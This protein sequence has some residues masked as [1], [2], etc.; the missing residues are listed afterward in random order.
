M[1]ARRR[2]GRAGDCAQVYTVSVYQRLWLGSAQQRFTLRIDRRLFVLVVRFLVDASRLT[3]MGRNVRRSTCCRRGDF[4]STAL[5][6]I[7]V[8]RA[9]IVGRSEGENVERD[10]TARPCDRSH[11]K[12]QG[13]A[14]GYAGSNRQTR[15]SALAKGQGLDEEKK[16]EK[17]ARI[18]ALVLARTNLGR[19]VPSC[20]PQESVRCPRSVRYAA[21]LQRIKY[22]TRDARR[23]TSE[24][25]TQK[26]DVELD[27]K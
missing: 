18:D 14:R 8:V 16:K 4:G 1:R 13:G 5:G 11:G 22:T 2:L 15:I 25:G 20:A 12:Q 23:R 10:G 3:R 6:S 17:N 21:V 24:A 9:V 19:R 26:Q 7:E 27:A